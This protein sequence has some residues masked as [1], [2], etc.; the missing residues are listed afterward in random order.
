ME[1]ATL[2]LRCLCICL[3]VVFCCAQTTW[4][5]LVGFN[6]DIH[7]DVPNARANDFHI[8]GRIQSG[9]PGGNW[10]SPPS[11]VWAVGGGFTDLNVGM[12]AD[13]SDP[14]ENW[15]IFW[16]D[17]TG[18]TF[19][20]C[21]VLHL[22]LLF[23]VECHN[24]A[25]DLVGWWT[26]NGEPI[27]QGYTPN[28]GAVPVVGFKVQDN[29]PEGS[30]VY[31]LRNDSHLMDNTPGAAPGIHT[32]IVQLELVSL[33]RAEA[34][35]YLGPLPQGFEQLQ[36]G[37]AGENLP[38]VAVANEKGVISEENPEDFPAESFFDVYV[39][40]DVPG[41]GH[42][43]T[44]Q[45]IGPGD[46][47]IARGTI[48][49]INNAGEPDYR[50]FWHMHEAHKA[51]LG[52]A[53]D[54]TNTIGP[55]MTAYPKGGPPGTGAH[56]PTVYV[57]GSP[58]HGPIHHQP[59]AVAYLGQT[60]TF[61]MEADIGPDQDG[62][63]NIDVRADSPDLDNGDDGVTVPLALP[64]CQKTSFKYWVTIVPAL[65]NPPDLYVNVWFDW[66]RDGDWDDVHQ[67]PQAGAIIQ[68]PEWAVQNQ[69]LSGLS[70]GPH[71][72]TTPDFWCW[73]PYA[74]D[75][76]EPIWM[77]ITISEQRWQPVAGAAGYGGAGPTGGYQYGETEDYYFTPGI[78]EPTQ[79]CCMPDG[80]C[81]NLDAAT[82]KA[83]GGIPQ[84]AGTVCLGDADGD[85]VDDACQE[86]PP[87]ELE[88][89]DAPE[90][91]LAYPSS[92]VTGSFPTCVNVPIAGWIQ[93]NNF[94]AYFGPAF[95]MEIEGNAGLCPLFNP[96]SYDRDECFNDGDAGLIIPPAYTIQGPVGSETVTSCTTSTGFLGV[97]CT[98]AN[99]GPD[100]DIQVTN[101]MPSNTVGYVNV[102]MDWN[103][104]GIWGGSSS[105]AVAAAPEHVL[106]DFQV[107][108]G[109]SGPLSGLNPPPFLIGPRHGFVWTRFT[110]SES[111]VGP[112]WTGEGVF[113]DGESEDYL[114]AVDSVAAP[115]LDFG[116]LPES[117]AGYQTTLAMNGPRH[118][119][120]P[121][122]HLGSSV[123]REP[124]GQPDP[125]ALGDDNDGNDDDDGI[126]FATA[127]IPGQQAVIDVYNGVGIPV[128]PNP[129][130]PQA[131]LEGW[132]DFNGDGSFAEAGDQIFFNLALPPVFGTY[133]INVPASA[134][135]GITTYARF[136]YSS[137][138]NGYG[139][140]G[141]ASDGEVEDYE[142]TIG[143]VYEPKPPL[144][145]VKWSQPPIEWNPA[146]G[147]PT[148][149]GWDEPSYSYQGETDTGVA[150][151]WKVV[152]DDFRCLGTMP[153]TSV[154]WWGSY[155]NWQDVAPPNRRPDA[156]HIAFWSNIR[157]GVDA[158]HSHPQKLLWRV[159]VPAERVKEE[160][161]GVDHF[162]DRFPDTCFQYNLDFKPD[163]YFHQD[164]FVDPDRDDR[165]LW[166]SILAVYKEP[167]PPEFKWGWKTRPAHWMDDAV[168]FELQ[169]IVLGPGIVANTASITPLK[170]TVC[171][172]TQSFDM[173]FE[174]DTDP[175]Y[176]KWEQ[177]F[178]GIRRWPH[179]EDE[180]SMAVETTVKAPV[181]KYEQKP[182]LNETGMDV[183]ATMYWYENVWLPQIMA[184]DFPCNE[185]GPLTDITVWGSWY[186][187]QLP[188]FLPGAASEVEFILRIYDD[189]PA[190]PTVSGYSMPGKEL[191]SHE[192]KPGQFE[193]SM[194]REDLQEGYYSPCSDPPLYDPVG[195][196]VCW[197]YDFHV[198]VNEAFRQK[199]TS[200]DR[201]V[202]WLSVEA[203]PLNEQGFPEPSRKRFGWKTSLEHWNDDAV[204]DSGSELPRM[205]KEL[206]YPKEHPYEGQSIDLAFRVG[207]LEET[208][209]LKILRQVAD[210]WECRKRTPVRAIVW[211]GSYMDY[212]YPA[213]KC[214]ELVPMP[215]KPDY[216]L[217]TIWTDIPASADVQY[218]RPGERKWEYRAYDY[219]EVLVGYD[220]HPEYDASGMP[221]IDMPR[222]AVFRYSVRLPRDHWFHQKEEKTIFWLSVVAVYEEGNDPVYNWGWTNHRHVFN[223]DAVA[224]EW[225][226][227]STGA[228]PTWVWKEQFD[229]AGNSEDMSFMLFTEPGCFPS[230]Y[231]TYDDWLALGKPSCWCSPPNGSGYQCD[232]DTDGV[233]S[234][235]PANYRIYLGDL[236]LL[237]SNWQRKIGD[238]ALDPCTDVDHR[239]SGFP[240]RYRVYLND[241]NILIGNWQKR[242]AELPGDCPRPE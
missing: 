109:Y 118:V 191:W 201:K 204:W 130:G 225:Q 80:T 27:G 141:Q 105:C 48:R 14:A 190:D 100:V 239:D 193:V 180:K 203:R 68:A 138:P 31:R 115:D 155:N 224:G 217:L 157:A 96:N 21:D 37:G 131:Y 47:L 178:T 168:T 171:D 177:S 64:H 242:D 43:E 94:G 129:P 169:K 214:P 143:P 159:E 221:N 70:P 199:G 51:E 9:D 189:I 192:F 241:L 12:A 231:T 38:M 29:P 10:S 212:N 124:D 19:S 39:E 200:D 36:R 236:N 102:L 106:V 158:D 119:I 26:L 117:A 219:D 1:T 172:Q 126:V 181:A 16:A 195:D 15:Y 140:N 112:G 182:D 8:E 24:V 56:Y 110:I 71:Q 228:P 223:D 210:D 73:H 146:F 89:G 156:W 63:N 7:M 206:V 6:P 52:D 238:P 88:F 175:N 151:E 49:Y 170:A 132:I 148:Y 154:H 4:G 226:L 205:W 188:G 135:P 176:V 53:P 28:G 227:S 153:V 213:C 87:D 240:A 197:Q 139:L 198:D 91:A 82:C 179:Y 61:E 164:D 149:C 125:N 18:T 3:L 58:P 59:R 57:A 237:V 186:R 187:D 45:P 196:T 77:R 90:G 235:F 17:W 220:K 81:F 30:Q 97:V 23:D 160:W 79:A 208:T 54:S 40:L 233:T 163:E 166:I 234:G 62:M 134:T 74:N 50:E 122:F 78:P 183:D 2:R 101:N 42:P 167:P 113:E 67:C 209:E 222:E 93:H 127:L 20:Y 230:W 84:G 41:A 232:G 72:I 165:V 107:P 229:Q 174:L 69:V 83:N 218:S 194:Y 104:D 85:G 92:G 161:V 95:D 215:V 11:L 128:P 123:D 120:V 150:P 173:A 152:A 76:P 185:T 207:T 46:I 145:N 162:P 202:Y 75:N 98:T 114:L 5:L 133:S 55:A 86:P 216:F 99:W 137:S 60:V 34:E 136:R 147:T 142:V 211:W 103:Q 66:D 25:V 111:R 22:G 44:R 108:N 121:G 184:D 65:V 32:E 116:D 33:A 13:R 35:E 144:E